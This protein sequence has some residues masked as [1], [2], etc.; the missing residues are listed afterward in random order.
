MKFYFPDINVWLAAAW[1]GHQHHPSASAWF[2]STSDGKIGFCHVTQLG[3][4]RLLTHPVVMHDEVMT[5]A[6]AWNA[7]DQFAKDDRF[8]FY[9]EPDHEEFQD[10]FRRLTM[11]KHIAHRQWPDAYL[12]AFAISAGLTLVTFDRGLK[13]LAGRESQLL[14]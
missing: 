10:T 13:S 8:T 9:P 2:A 6:G 7:F 4:L 12:T 14:R 5:P 1:R 11:T 3:F